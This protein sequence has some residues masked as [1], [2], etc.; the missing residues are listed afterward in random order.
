MK[1]SKIFL[2]IAALIAVIAGA[3]YLARIASHNEVIQ[4]IISTYGYIGIFFLALISGFNLVVPIPAISF[5][6]L[7]IESGLSFWPT[8]LIIALGMTAAD[9]ISY[10]LVRAGRDIVSESWGNKIFEKFDAL[11]EKYE[12]YP[13]A[14]LFIFAS[15]VPLPNEILLVPATFWG[16]SWKQLL[17]VVL[18]GNLIFNI[19]FAKG[20]MNVFNAI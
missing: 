10:V 13:L 14:I 8:I 18:A 3:L 15:V 20:L 16:Y 12:R 19:L 2:Q 11:R 17:P 5:L 6:P 7:F 9:F 4:E 1:V